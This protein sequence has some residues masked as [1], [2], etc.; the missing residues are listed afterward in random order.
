MVFLSENNAFEP[1]IYSLVEE[2]LVAK[3]S[4]VSSEHEGTHCQKL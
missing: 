3:E 2:P 4:R 1:E